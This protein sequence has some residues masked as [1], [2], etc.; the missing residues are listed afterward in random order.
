MSAARGAAARRRRKHGGGGHDEGGGGHER[1]LVT[2]ADML[3]LLLVLFIVLFS[4]S[5]VDQTKFDA[6]KRSLASVFGQGQQHIL[7]GGTGIRDGGVD[8]MTQPVASELGQNSP[9]TAA[10]APLNDANIAQAVAQQLNNFDAI[11][12]S[13]NDAL[14]AK[15]MAGD[16][17]FTVDQRGMVITVVTTDLLF[18]GNSADLLS[19]GN[20][21]LSVIAPPL[22]KYPNDIEVDGYTNQDKVSTY[23]YK[24]GWQ[25]SAAR[26]A[27]VAYYLQGHGISD[28]RLD[29]KGMND[30]NPKYPPSDPRASTHN[31]R[32]E[33]VVLSGLPSEAGAQL[34]AQAAKQ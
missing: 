18:G 20:A 16:V 12:K 2:Y 23:P 5:V 1:W 22:T 9:L 7:E 24:S 25:L 31:R 15:G 6:L 26:A 11:K 32:V 3:T 34:A 4:M 21:L 28:G 14:V 30:Q 17:D 10:Q 27:E 29:A 33:I 8:S 19:K 13:I